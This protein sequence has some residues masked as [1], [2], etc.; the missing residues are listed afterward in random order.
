MNQTPPRF[1]FKRAAQSLFGL[2]ALIWLILAGVSLARLTGDRP[3]SFIFWV[4]AALM[5]GNA[6]AMLL[7]AVVIGR[8]KRIYYLFA[9][10]VLLVNIVMS[11]TDQVGW[12]DLLTLFIDVV[13]L[14]ILLGGR[15][16][17]WPP[18]G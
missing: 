5:V 10:L 16:F 13:L 18:A 17:F 8:R 15:P 9:L 2:N 7:C 6:G 1:G 12:A 4:I 3:N 14:G 11:V